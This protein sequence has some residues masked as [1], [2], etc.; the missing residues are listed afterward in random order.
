[1]N[2]LIIEDESLLAD[3]LEEIVLHIDPSHTILAKLQSIDEAVEWLNNNQCDIIFMDIQ[4]SDGL[5]F[6][7]FEKVNVQSPVIFTTA[8]DQYAIEAFNVNGIAYI[9]KPIDNAEIEK[10]LQKHELLKQSYLKTVENF[11]S[12][13]SQID[14]KYKEQ[15][16]LTL[17]PTKKIVNVKSIV[18][19]QA[20]DRYVFVFINTSQRMFSNYTL[21]DLETILDPHLFFRINRTFIVYRG[22][23]KEWMS[24]TKGRIRVVLNTDDSTDFIVS[25]ARIAEFRLWIEK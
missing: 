23:I 11:I 18:Y 24:Y 7:I 21:R 2:I 14:T 9:L 16:L 25:R 8:Y 4:L 6:T 15:L 13:Y 3:E 12:D 1:M 20:E 19:F 17:G 10:A 22:C 5:S